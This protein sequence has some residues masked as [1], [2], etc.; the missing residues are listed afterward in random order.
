MGYCESIK[1]LF[2][3]HRAIAQLTYAVAEHLLFA[4]NVPESTLLTGGSWY[5]PAGIKQSWDIL[6]FVVPD[7]K[8]LCLA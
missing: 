7:S 1:E 4:T 2:V 6:W 5:F 3:F 8:S